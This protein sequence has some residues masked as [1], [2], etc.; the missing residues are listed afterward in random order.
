MVDHPSLA[1]AFRFDEADL[2]HNRQ[3]ELTEAQTALLADVARRR[4]CARG[5]ATAVIL[6]TLGL[7]WMV[8]LIAGGLS[9]EGSGPL[10]A[11]LVVTA[12]V[13]L[14]GGGALLVGHRRSRDLRSGTVSTAEGPVATESVTMREQGS[15]VGD[16]YRVELGGVRLLV[17]TEAQMEAFEEGAT[18]RVFYIA[19]P[20]AHHV[21]SAERLP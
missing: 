18:Y 20:P 2:E 6:A 17:G 16:Q 21:L 1:D 7:L 13:L 8:L 11:L 15:K 14:L 9:G 12:V 4:G 5:A 3:G 10:V 19:D